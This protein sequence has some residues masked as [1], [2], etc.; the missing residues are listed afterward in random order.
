MSFS[1]GRYR[2]VGGGTVEP[3]TQALRKQEQDTVAFAETL[4]LDFELG[5]GDNKEI[6][7]S[8]HISSSSF[9]ALRPGDY[10]VILKQDALGGRTINWPVNVVGNPPQ[11]DPTSL[12]TSIYEFYFDGTDFHF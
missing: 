11:P 12:S 10:R 4:T 7:L 1:Y 5:D 3:N 9:A 8:G 2:P 6:T